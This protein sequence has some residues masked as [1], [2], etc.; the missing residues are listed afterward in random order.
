MK[1]IL[2]ATDGS[3]NSKRALLEAKDYSK[4]TGR[5]IVI[6]TVVEPKGLTTVGYHYKH[7]DKEAKKEGNLLLEKSSEL[8]HDL[9]E[10]VETKLLVGNPADLI[11][12]EA[13]EEEYHLIIMGNRGLGTFQRAML[14]SVSHNVLNHAKV[15]TFIVK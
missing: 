9:E 6:V 4:C 7:L 15:N 1:K 11:I 14:G 10:N 12:K 2:A 8:L 3:E 13:E 5:D